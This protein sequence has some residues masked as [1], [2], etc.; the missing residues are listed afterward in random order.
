MALANLLALFANFGG[1]FQTSNSFAVFSF[2]LRQCVKYLSLSS[3][4][5]MDNDCFFETK[6]DALSMV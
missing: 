1:F 3:T 6:N 4:G 2:D 5:Q